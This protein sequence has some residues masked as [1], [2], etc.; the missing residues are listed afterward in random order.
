[1]LTVTVA[2]KSLGE[3][4]AWAININDTLRKF[5]SGA[6]GEA[7]FPPS[8]K[9]RQSGGSRGATPSAITQFSA[10]AAQQIVKQGLKASA[11]LSIAEV[12]QLDKK[13]LYAFAGVDRTTIERKAKNKELLSDDATVKLLT[14]TELIGE[15]ADVFGLVGEASRWLTTAHP[16]LD[17]DTP[18]QHARTPWGAA[19]VRSM[20]VALKYGGVV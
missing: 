16:V 11:M 7:I 2:K 19:R 12:S 8:T 17:G 13:A 10:N 1:M 20:L 9:S 3:P 15:A 18:L 5:G 4:L 6:K 14:A